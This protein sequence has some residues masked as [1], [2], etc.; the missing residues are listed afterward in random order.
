MLYAS[1]HLPVFKGYTNKQSKQKN[2]SWAKWIK[3][4]QRKK[5]GMVNY[6]I[7]GEKATLNKNFAVSKL[8][9]QIRLSLPKYNPEKST[10]YPTFNRWNS[11]WQRIK[12]HR[13]TICSFLSDLT[14]SDNQVLLW[15]GQACLNYSTFAIEYSP[16]DAVKVKDEGSPQPFF[17][18]WHDIS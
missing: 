1:L 5:H 6:G 2:S 12:C 14:N 16:P 17:I 7:T 9:W 13:L 15:D 3:F 4:S 11:W 18:S 8:P 10:L